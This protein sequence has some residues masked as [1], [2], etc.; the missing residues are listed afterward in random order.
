MF[1]VRNP[2][3]RFVSGFHSRKRQG[4]PRYQSPWSSGEEVAFSR[5]STPNALANALSSDDEL[6]RMAAEDAMDSIS[7][8]RS[9]QWSWFQNESYFLARRSDILFIGFQE[10]LGADFEILKGI[11]NL[12]TEAR[13]PDDVITS[14]RSPANVDKELDEAAIANLNAWYRRDQDFLKLC[15]QV[16][17]RTRLRNATTPDGPFASARRLVVSPA[18]VRDGR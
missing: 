1:I 14:H 13:L 8:I 15:R 4:R 10:T 7:H 16:K 2:I 6:Q 5:F 17:D 11:L 3:S 18:S 9:P 12:P